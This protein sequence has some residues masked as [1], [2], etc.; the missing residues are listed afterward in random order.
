MRSTSR[1]RGCGPIGAR[2]PDRWTFTGD[3]HGC[4]GELETPLGVLGYELTWNGKEVSIAPPEG[5]RAIFVGD[6]P[7][8]QSDPTKPNECLV[9]GSALKTAECLILG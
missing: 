9:L 3:V 4:A 1:A 6:G 2:K 7:T 5:G 8:D